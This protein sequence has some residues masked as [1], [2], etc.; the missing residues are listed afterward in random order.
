MGPAVCLEY[1]IKKVQ[2]NRVRY[3][4]WRFD[5]E[6]VN[7]MMWKDRLLIKVSKIGIW[8]SVQVDQGFFN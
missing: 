6:K 2:M 3:C 8:I 7:A 1:E 4:C 5:I